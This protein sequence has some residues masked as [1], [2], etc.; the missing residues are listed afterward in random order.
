MDA[1]RGTLLVATTRSRLRSTRT[2]VPMLRASRQ[3][4][5]QLRDAPGL[6]RALSVVAGPTEFWTVTVW[7]SRDAMQAFMRSG[8]HG[9]FMWRVGGWLGAFWLMRWSPGSTERGTWGGLVLAARPDAEPEALPAGAGA[10]PG[11]LADEVLAG[12]PELR[13][14]MG[15]SGAAT[16]ADAP[17]TARKRA[18]LAQ[19]SGAIVVAAAAPWGM[20]ALLARMRRL[21]VALRRDPDL[22]AAT[23]GMGH[24]GELVLIAAWRSEDAAAR[25]VD[26]PGVAALAARP[27]RTVWA[28]AWR[29]EHEF[30]TWDGARLRARRGRPADCAETA[31]PVERRRGVRRRPARLPRSRTPRRA[32]G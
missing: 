23:V 9:A 25:F 12:M 24:G 5:L 28:H 11:S 31:T 6:V 26:G 14:A 17:F 8:D 19:A 22:F 1:P 21:A 32:R 29:P 10:T 13:A 4:R 2:F 20:P 18:Q 16:Y 3:I 15:A 30:G 27:G 7:T